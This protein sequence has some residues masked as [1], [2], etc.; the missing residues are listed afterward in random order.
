MSVQSRQRVREP[1]EHRI[2]KW[3]KAGFAAAR[4]NCYV[5]I[6]KKF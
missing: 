1:S 3:Q 6:L 2:W 5:R 4:R